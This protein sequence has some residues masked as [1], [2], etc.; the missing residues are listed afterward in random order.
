MHRSSAYLQPSSFLKLACAGLLLALVALLSVFSTPAKAWYSPSRTLPNLPDGYNLAPTVAMD[1]QGRIFAAWRLLPRNFGPSS[2]AY[3]RGTINNAGE[4]N[5]ERAIELTPRADALNPIIAVGPNGYVHLTYQDRDGIKYLENRG[6]GDNRNWGDII[7]LGSGFT[8]SVTVGP[9][10]QV[11]VT[12]SDIR[13]DSSPVLFSWRTVN[14]GWSAE[15]GIWNGGRLAR[16]NRVAVAGTGTD[17]IVHIAVEYKA[18]DR[19]G[20]S[21][22]YLRDTPNGPFGK[23]RDM[24][25]ETR[26][27]IGIQPNIAV[28]RQTNTVALV[29]SGERS[30]GYDLV[31]TQSDNGGIDFRSAQTLSKSVNEWAFQSS[32]ALRNN[33]AHVT[34]EIAD[35]NGRSFSGKTVNYRR[36]DRVTN[37]WGGWVAIGSES[38]A[39][40]PKLAMNENFVATVWSRGTATDDLIQY[41]VDKLSEPTPPTATATATSAAPTATP[42]PTVTPSPTATSTPSPTPIPAPISRLTLNNGV[43]YTNSTTVNARITN[44]GGPANEYTLVVGG[45][46]ISGAFQPDGDSSMVVPLTVENP[47]QCQQYT[48]TGLLRGPSGASQVAVGTFTVDQSVQARVE[49]VNPNLES[50]SRMVA[51]GASPQV[52][53]GNYGDPGY[54]RDT[55]FL[56]NIDSFENN[57]SGLKDYLVGGKGE[58]AIPQQNDRRWQA[59][60]SATAV[61]ATL[62]SDQPEGPYSFSIFL[63][64]RVGNISSFQSRDGANNAR[65]IIFDVTNPSARAGRTNVVSTTSNLQP[66]GDVARLDFTTSPLTVTDNLYPGGYYGVAV[67]VNTDPSGTKTTESEWNLYSAVVPGKIGTTF[68][69]NLSFGRNPA[70]QAGQDMYVHLR[71]IDGAGN[72]SPIGDTISSQAVRPTAFTSVFKQ[73]MPFLVR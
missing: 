39:T 60:G 12:W 3:A 27:P 59:L 53:P 71:F 29:W 68:D 51:Q 10:N 36:Y 13:G 7:T 26:G 8:P 22:G 44:L 58:T 57:C 31:Y 24:P 67:L 38:P 65:P 73:F 25:V 69:W 37:T 17:A 48:V 41:S 14:G 21:I 15:R 55:R 23:A 30:D 66:A 2:I 62:P 19:C 35:W 6:N 34:L 64:D 5:W 20:F 11:Y 40:S 70:A 28:D 4:V 33:L 45:K 61:W 47:V 50:N 16:N 52:F 9:D 72:L 49:A 46:T 56:V 63:R 54:T 32:V 42:S 43:E 18:C 1:D